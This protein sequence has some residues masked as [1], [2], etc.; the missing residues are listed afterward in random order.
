MLAALHYKQELYS[1]KAVL[2]YSRKDSLRAF[3]RIEDLILFT[4]TQAKVKTDS[5]EV[6]I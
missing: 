6:R 4:P 3:H 5:L 2:S 1:I